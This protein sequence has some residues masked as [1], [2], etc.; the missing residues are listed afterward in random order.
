MRRN[1][2]YALFLTLALSSGTVFGGRTKTALSASQDLWLGATNGVRV[3]E[4]GVLSLGPA[5]VKKTSLP[6]TPLCALVL[7]ED[8]FIGTGPSGDLLRVSADKTSVFH[9]F[10]EPLVTSLAASPDGGLLVGTAGPAKVYKVGAT[11][12]Q[13]TLAAEIP[14]QYVW[15]LVNTNDGLIAASGVPGKLWRVAPGKNP[16]PV[17]DF[18]A[19][20]ARC[21]LQD[22]ETLWVGTASP[23]ALYR[24]EKGGRATLAATLPQE[25]VAGLALD[26]GAILVAANEKAESSASPPG[27]EQ[28]AA[29]SE[30]KGAV[31]YRLEKS[32]ALVPIRVL[33]STVLSTAHGPQGA[34]AGTRD[35]ALIEIAGGK[36]SLMAR[37]PKDQLS[38]I[39]GGL[40]APVVMTA[41][42]GA[43]WAVSTKQGA[44]EASYTSP[45]I[46]AATAAR[47][48]VIEGFGTGAWELFIRAG[49]S[50]EPD[51]FWSA[52]V[53]A[54]DSGQLQ[55]SRYY[56]WRAVLNPPQATLKSV[57]F[58]YRPVNRPPAFDD[59]RVGPPGEISVKNQSQLG[60]RL[61]QEI[62]EKDRPFPSLAMS[63][64]SDS[65]PQTYYLYGFRMISWKVSDPDGDD[66]R[67]DVRLRPEGSQ[68][69]ITLAESVADP[70]YVFKTRAL[71]D[72]RYQVELSANDGLS[73][74]EGEALATLKVLPLF[75]VDNTP[76]QLAEKGRGRDFIELEASDNTA[77]EAARASI[78]GGAW[79]PVEMEGR[80]GSKSALLRLS[81]PSKG[82][83]FLAVEVV[84][85][86][87][88][89]T[90]KGFL[91]P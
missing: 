76:P 11:D 25:E 52:F 50:A 47:P 22:G 74:P 75:E 60:E 53:P 84:D 63:K 41:N 61:V 21:L 82:R 26:G 46:D 58:A 56:Q 67:V 49:N 90:V 15:A 78:D 59:V 77:V 5:F 17:A 54:K 37:W 87:E 65:A 16:E 3:S 68:E 33:P 88:N 6:G 79:E 20:H 24:V 29:S 8:I 39:A 66:V 89:S 72:G 14:A 23:A 12:G 64:P 57:S 9:H 85:P 31:L 2:A 27:K 40:S 81:L 80:I 38:A 86:Y 18:N 45:V 7:N 83:H 1:V 35:G 48:G 70:F 30:A 32:A 42:P 28:P 71:P 73:N 13:A 4:E 19:V 55:P 36:A 43:L 91:V 51:A 34:Y 69:W 10:A 44:G 62:H